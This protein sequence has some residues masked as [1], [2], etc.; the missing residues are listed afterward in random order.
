MLVFE[1]LA[2]M[3]ESFGVFGATVGDAGDDRLLT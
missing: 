3:A 2:V 1:D